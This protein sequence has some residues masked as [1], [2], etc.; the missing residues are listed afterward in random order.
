MPSGRAPLA[1]RVAASHGPDDELAVELLQAGEGEIAASRLTAGVERLL[2]A[3]RIAASEELRERAL[4]RAVECL[5]LAGDMPRANSHFDAVLACSDSPRRSYTIA[6]LTAANG[7][8]VEAE[9]AFREVMARPD[10]GAIP[11]S[12]VPPRDARAV[13]R[14]AGPRARRAWS[15]P[16]G[17]S[18][19]PDLPPTAR[20]T[21]RQAL[22]IGLVMTGRGDEAIAARASSRP[23]GSS[24][25]RSRPS[26]SRPGPS[27]KVWWGDL[28]GAD[29]DLSA[30]IRWSRAGVPFR[31]LPNAYGGLA[32]VEY[33]AR[34][35]ER[36][37][38][39]TPIWRCRS[40]RTAS[41]CGTCH[42]STRSRAT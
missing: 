19:V 7:R 27:V 41:A 15:G 32:E 35:L 38:R 17:R 6:L 26:C 3:S 40:A 11:S 22:A 18:T 23:R 37:S 42:T 4:L 5:V 39:R 30:V 28:A 29:E 1:H 20:T 2:L 21:A 31:S 36:R 16:A 10:Y 34:A 9:A 12:R 8:L 24:P 33:R 25:S 13:V 14:V